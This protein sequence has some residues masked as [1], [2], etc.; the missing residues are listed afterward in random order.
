MYSENDFR[1]YKERYLCHSDYYPEYSENDFRLYHHG[2][3]GMKWGK[4][5]GP[6]YPLGASD[7]SAS[8][9]K[10]GWRK[11][12]NLSDNQ[13]KAL[14]VA[15][16]AVA[17]TAAAVGAYYLL[18]S[19]DLRSIAKAGQTVVKLG[20]QIDSA[21]GLKLKD[22]IP[23]DRSIDY[24][25]EDIRKVNPHMNKTNCVACSVTNELRARGFD[26]SAKDRGSD[27][28]S[29]SEL[30]LTFPD[31]HMNNLDDIAKSP[32]DAFN[33]MNKEILKFGEGSRGIVVG[34][35]NDL[36]KDRIKSLYGNKVSFDGHAFNWEVKNGKVL[37][38]DAQPAGGLV[39]DGD[40]N[41]MNAFAGFDKDSFKWG[42]LSGLEIDP[43]F[44]KN[45]VYNR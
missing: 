11:S 18:K 17:T 33:K 23:V 7:H 40:M 25:K 31:F 9:R 32:A 30:E 16:V 15:G 36:W 4:R 8:E 19:G 14:K 34:Q 6:P 45:F 44:S 28:F 2:I 12:L 29:L 20:G 43:D 3:L 10:A 37:F 24:I 13:K 41:P 5:N 22:S 27:T 35:Y 38:Y 39:Y 1:L 42:K 26:V 21:T